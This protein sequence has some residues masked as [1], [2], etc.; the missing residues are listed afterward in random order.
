MYI[1]LTFNLTSKNHIE[2]VSMLGSN[3]GATVTVLPVN[4][5]RARLIYCYQKLCSNYA[6]LKIKIA[7]PISSQC[8]TTNALWACRSAI[9][10]CFWI[11]VGIGIGPGINWRLGLISC[12]HDVFVY[13]W[14]A[15][16]RGAFPYDKREHQP[17]CAV[18]VHRP[19]AHPHC[20]WN[21]ADETP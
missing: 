1:H 3:G 10:E 13:S 16:S 20:H 7:D 18:V 19:D 6:R 17:A 2:T 12:E 11:G 9:F 5:D 4:A 14:P 15:V 8:L 21:L